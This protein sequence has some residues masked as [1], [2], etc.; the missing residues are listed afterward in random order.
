ML[1]LLNVTANLKAI[2]SL[3]QNAAIH[4]KLWWV[5]ASLFGRGTSPS[6]AASGIQLDPILSPSS[7]AVVLHVQ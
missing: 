7:A 1:I 5:L 3:N 4:R 2:K 6:I